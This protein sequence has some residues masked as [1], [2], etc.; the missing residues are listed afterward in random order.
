MTRGAV[1]A[2]RREGLEV[3]LDAGAAAGIGSRD[4]H[5]DGGRFGGGRFGG[6][7]GSG[8]GHGVVLA[9]RPSGWARASLAQ[10]AS[11]APMRPAWTP[12][13]GASGAGG[14][15]VTEE[16]AFGG[17]RRRPRLSSPTLMVSKPDAAPASAARPSRAARAGVQPARGGVGAA[18]DGVRPSARHDRDR[19]GGGRLRLLQR[20]GRDREMAGGGPARIRDPVRAQHHDHGLRGAAG[21]PAR[22]W[23]GA[24]QPPARARCWPAAC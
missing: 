17:T 10:V 9:S 23:G 11:A 19:P 15:R 2:E 1:D 5:R 3:G 14:D 24:A 21:R 4:G 20:P 16:G 12:C 6:P 7:G 13:R 18:Q 8:W 22:L